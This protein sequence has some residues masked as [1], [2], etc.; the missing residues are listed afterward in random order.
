MVRRPK[1]RHEFFDRLAAKDGLLDFLRKHLRHLGRHVRWWIEPE[2]LVIIEFV[3]VE[4]DERIGTTALPAAL[5]TLTR[6][7]DEVVIGGTRSE[8]AG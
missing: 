6:A 1:A 3:V 2:I 5:F 4:I 8:F 7:L